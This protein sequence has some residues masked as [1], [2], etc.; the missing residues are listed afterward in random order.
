MTPFDK[1]KNQ[2]VVKIKEVYLPDASSLGG[3]INKFAKLDFTGAQEDDNTRD[4]RNEGE[5]Q[6]PKQKKGGLDF[7]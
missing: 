2:L 1:V 4:R 3:Q 5:T 6:I 7:T